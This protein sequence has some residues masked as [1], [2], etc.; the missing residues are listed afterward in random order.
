[1][2]PARLNC[3]GSTIAVRGETKQ[4]HDGIL[5]AFEDRAG[6]YEYCL[7]RYH[8]ML[9]RGQRSSDQPF[10]W[11]CLICWS[12]SL[13]SLKASVKWR[14]PRDNERVHRQGQNLIGGRRT[15]PG[16]RPSRRRVHVRP[17]KQSFK[18]PPSLHLHAWTTSVGLRTLSI[19]TAHQPANRLSWDSAPRA[20]LELVPKARPLVQVA[21]PAHPVRDRAPSQR[22][23]Q[24]DARFNPRANA[25]AGKLLGL[26]AGGAGAASDGGVACQLVRLSRGKSLSLSPILNLLR[27][28]TIK[29]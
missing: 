20:Q 17:A 10:S 14:R 9:I 5:F 6:E 24:P 7:Q 21:A 11:P 25:G 15:T 2:P 16:L 18:T 3:N 4:Y 19:H 13:S 12:C 1:M 8:A 28:H 22:D 27:H 26:R 29:S 23:R